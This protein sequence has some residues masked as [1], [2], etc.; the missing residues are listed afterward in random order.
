M[1]EVFGPTITDDSDE[2]IFIPLAGLPPRSAR[3]W[4][5]TAGPLDAEVSEGSFF[6]GSPHAAAVFA[7][8]F[9]AFHNAHAARGA[10]VGKDQTLFNALLLLHPERFPHCARRGP[11]DVAARRRRAR[12]VRLGVVLLPIRARAGGGARGDACDVE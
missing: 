8:D 2:R 12:R 4:T 11:A 10:F 5:P 6:G 7:A 1:L 3:T 9:Y